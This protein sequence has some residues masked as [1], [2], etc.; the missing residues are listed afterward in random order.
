MEIQLPYL[1]VQ[2]NIILLTDVMNEEEELVFGRQ[3]SWF[4]ISEFKTLTAYV[5]LIN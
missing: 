4:Q 3:K 2:E 1:D 5:G